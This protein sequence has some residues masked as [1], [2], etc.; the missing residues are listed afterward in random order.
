MS[1]LARAV[2]QTQW[3]AKWFSAKGITRSAA[4]AG[5]QWLAFSRIS[6]WYGPSI[7][8]GAGGGAAGQLGVL[9]ALR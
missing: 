4:S 8:S 6:N 3:V 7:S 1:G 5:S 9:A 2:N